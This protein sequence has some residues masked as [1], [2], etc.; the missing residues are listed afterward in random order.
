MTRALPAPDEEFWGL[1]A[2]KRGPYEIVGDEGRLQFVVMRGPVVVK[3]FTDFFEA[4][5]FVRSKRRMEGK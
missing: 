1:P 5:R 3:V 2:W 4:A